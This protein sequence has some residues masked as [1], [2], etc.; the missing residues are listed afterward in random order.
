VRIC[1]KGKRMTETLKVIH[2]LTPVTDRARW[3]ADGLRD[4]YKAEGYSVRVENRIH[5]IS[6]IAKK[7]LS[8][9]ND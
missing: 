8:K 3:K 4:K 9:D 1:G 7:V 6:V 5:G 2:H